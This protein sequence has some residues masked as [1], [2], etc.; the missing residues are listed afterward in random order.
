M[1][2][3]RVIRARDGQTLCSIAFES[4]FRNCNRLRTAN[5]ALASRA[6]QPGDQVNVPVVT[7]KSE[8]GQVDTLHRFRRLGEP[9]ATVF[10]IQDHNRA[11]PEQARGDA[12]RNLA[13]SNYV[14]TRQGNGFTNADWRDDTFFG[15]DAG[16][17][18]DPDHFK[19]QV[20]DPAA[21]A[22]GDSE[23]KVKLQSQMPVLSSA[24]LITRWDNILTGGNPVG[25]TV[26]EVTCRQVAANSPW[27][28][29]HYLRLV[30]DEQ[31]RT[32]KRPHG[33]SSPTPD[34][35]RDVSKQV[36][37][38]PTTSDRRVE[39]LDLRVVADKPA[40][41][42]EAT[43]PPT[44]QC[45]SRAIAGVGKSEKV[46]R[47][48]VVRV[49]GAAG[50]GINDDRVNK[51]VFENLR[52]TM[53]QANVG[54]QLVEG[55][56][57][58]TPQPKNMI[59]VSDY[60]GVKA[61]G[62]GT[63]TVRV[64]LSSGD[65]TAQIQTERK[66]TPR[67][68]ADKLVRALTTQGVRC[69]VSP[70]PPIET[71]GDNFG[72]CDILCFNADNSLATVLSATSTD[73]AQKLSHSGGFNT[74]SV[75]DNT[76]QYNTAD[77]PAPP[78]LILASIDFRA[79]CK[80]FNQG[81]SHLGVLVVGGFTRPEL[82]GKALLPF[83]GIAARIRPLT[84]MSMCVFVDA[85]GVD[86]RTVLTH[87][88]GHVLLDAFHCT[89]TGDPEKDLFDNAFDVND[90][91]GFSEWMAAFNRE[92]TFIHKRMSDQ[93]LT[94]RFNIVKV[95]ASSIDS[96]EKTLGTGGNLSCV[97][98]FRTLSASVLT[99]LRRLNPAPGADL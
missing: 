12:Q 63:M 80:N 99:G 33:R 20:F 93:P 18:V 91:L 31:D 44:A 48:K 21:R 61:D 97:E 55:R 90:K 59:V 23:L 67:E 73:G 30:I 57:I 49:G 17:S 14:P 89:S 95:G 92:P 62:G 9:G 74:M 45:R 43:T 81:G 40:S 77:R 26:L 69:R 39:I 16:A 37:V 75:K 64:R 34:A 41:R 79:V 52:L 96:E 28:R 72:C 7:P 83:R 24:E 4:G 86:A 84:E 68:T 58:D 19:V 15:H 56:I 85:G 1:D 47:V 25:G 36:L 88:A 27:Y 5:P 3:A 54:V 29:S 82:L 53:A 78:A 8:A 60:D 98:R 22:R 87:E 13:V 35:G 76:A 32:F 6:L 38:V 2:I 94:V 65:V 66:H 42:C 70:N 51:M 10:I 46:M 50:S 11:T 71:S